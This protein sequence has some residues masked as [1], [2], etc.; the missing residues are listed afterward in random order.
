MRF[1]AQ[2]RLVRP[3][4]SSLA[5]LMTMAQCGNKQAYRALLI[6]CRSWMRSYFSR[7]VP[8]QDLDDLVQ[9]TLMALHHNLATYDQTRAFIPWLAA[10]SRYRWVDHLRR[11]YRAAEVPLGDQMADENQELATTSRISLD[12]LFAQLPARQM[13]AIELVKI[14]GLSIAEAAQACGQS[15]SLVKINIH[16]GLKRLSALI[17][18]A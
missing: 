13:Q 7:R 9:E 2:S 1:Y 12:R 14:Q 3:D 5:R 11:S 15:E 4:E 8:P 17:E 10:I 18:K 16:R 6:E